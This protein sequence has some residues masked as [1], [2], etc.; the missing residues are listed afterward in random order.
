MPFKAQEKKERTLTEQIIIVLLLASLM[1]SF[2]HYFFKESDAYNRAGFSALVNAF[3]VG[4]N[5][6]HAQWIMD[7]QPRF[8][9]VKA[10]TPGLAKTSEVD[11][12]SVS[13]H[14]IPL[15][16]KGWIDEDPSFHDNEGFTR[17]EKIWHYVL[18][19]PLNFMKE[20][21]SIVA[22]LKSSKKIN[23]IIC[24]YHSAAGLYFEYDT[25]SGNVSQVMVRKV[26][27]IG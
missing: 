2:I 23:G 13:T 5:N 26:K 14:K 18:D 17:C 11:E 9:E 1:A 16:K 4:I 25:T 19:R 20:P 27:Q 7:N 6:S 15:N 22:T 8:I 12:H 21:I 10:L 3:H 24:K